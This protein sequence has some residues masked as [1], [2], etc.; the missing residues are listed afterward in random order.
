MFRNDRELGVVLVQESG[1]LL[2]HKGG[3]TGQVQNALHISHPESGL[4]NFTEDALA[5]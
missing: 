2:L 4:V 1:R 5:T 3:R